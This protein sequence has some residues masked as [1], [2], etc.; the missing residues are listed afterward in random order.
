MVEYRVALGCHK[1]R[2]GTICTPLSFILD[3]SVRPS[4]EIN[5]MINLFRC[6]DAPKYQKKLS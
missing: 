3:I 1:K 2:G 4:A 6:E 5:V